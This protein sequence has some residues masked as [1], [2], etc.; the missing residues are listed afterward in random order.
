MILS[1][2]GWESRHETILIITIFFFLLS[3]RIIMMIDFGIELRGNV[4]VCVW[5]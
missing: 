1:T 2:I 3:C 5:V 4:F